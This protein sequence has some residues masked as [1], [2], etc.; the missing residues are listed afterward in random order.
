ML[1][2]ANRIYIHQAKSHKDLEIILDIHFS[3]GNESTPEN[4]T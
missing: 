1:V 3:E 4:I 2:R